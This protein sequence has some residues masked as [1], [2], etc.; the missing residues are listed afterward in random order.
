MAHVDDTT[1]WNTIH[2]KTHKPGTAHS[3]Y[4]QEKEKLFPRSALIVDLGGGTGEDAI[5]F[6]QK[7][8]SV[9]LLDI[10]EFALKVAEDK[11]KSANFAS[12]L[13]TRK[14]DYG[15][16]AFP[17][18][19][20]SVDVVYSRIAL[21]Y[22]DL[23]HTGKLF[24]EIYRILKPGAN[25]YITLKAPDDPDEMDYLQ[26]VTTP[27]ELNV[28]IENGMLRSR[29]TIEQLRSAL[30]KQGINSYD[31]HPFR[32]DLGARRENHKEILHLNEIIFKKV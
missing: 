30:H 15:L 9:V 7:G 28:F 32:E 14:V 31:I 3:H 10:S 19:E 13:V 21:N 12:K 26:K 29:F 17:V 11:A 16:E 6:L 5:Y 8:H 2:Q 24:R 20:N 18:K 27:Y 23:E 25:A 1:R 22:F 4:A